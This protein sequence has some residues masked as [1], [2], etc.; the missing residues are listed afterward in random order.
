MQAHP[1]LRIV[2]A[3][4]VLTGCNDTRDLAPASPSTPWQTEIIRR[5]GAAVQPQSPMPPPPEG[6]ARQFSAPLQA[7]PVIPAA[8]RTEIDPNHPYTLTE[9][10]DLAQTRNPVTR[11]A[12]EQARQAAIAVGISQ[13]TLL[14]ELTVD[15]L[16]GAN[17]TATPFPTALAPR[18]YITSDGQAIFPELVLKY[19]LIDFGGRRAGIEAA[20]Q[21]SFAANAGFTAV[22]QKLI[23]DVSQ[24]YFQLDGLTA[25]LA[26][27]R[28]ALANAKLVETAANAKMARGEGTVTEIAIARRNV[29]QAALA[30]PQAEQGLNAAR[31]SLLSLLDLPPQSRIQVQDSAG[32]K[33]TAGT[34]RTLDEMMSDA[35]RQRPDLLA[36]LGQLR[37]SEQGVALARSEFYPRLSIASNIQG[38]IGQIRTDDGPYSSVKQ[39][40]YGVYLRLDWTLYQG[41]ARWNRLHAEQS[42]ASQAEASLQQASTEALREI[43][44]A[45]DNLNTGLAQNDA[46]TALQAAA[47]TAFDAATSAYAHGVGTL[48]DAANAQTALAMARSASAQAHSQALVNAAALAFV[49]GDLSSAL[50]PALT[51]AAP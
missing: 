18:G 51:A 43:A 40:Q 23:M 42:R 24:A 6:S 2:A 37:A 14:P 33:L 20:K 8:D 22:H 46:A 12:W 35:L 7:M 49:T 5:D 16:G 47:Q 48:T 29:A 10:I 41:G 25:Q 1:F 38:N 9:L 30:I 13:A 26:A 50:S 11:I 45:Y 28:T 27:A 39:P 32:R 19:L 34:I 36:K 21:L 17:H 15:A 3:S 44:L 31:V 4:A